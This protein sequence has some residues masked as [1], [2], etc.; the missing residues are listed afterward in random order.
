ME[1]IRELVARAA[2]ENGWNLP[3]PFA[4]KV[5]NTDHYLLASELQRPLY[6]LLE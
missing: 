5:A 2:K 6:L 3:A 1:Q 4:I